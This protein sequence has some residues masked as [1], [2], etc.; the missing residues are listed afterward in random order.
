MM[1]LDAPLMFFTA[2]TIMSWILFIKQSARYGF[3]RIFFTCL[4]S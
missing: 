2:A 1:A 3:I 4:A